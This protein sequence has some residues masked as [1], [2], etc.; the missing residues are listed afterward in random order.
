MCNIDIQEVPKWRPRKKDPATYEQE[1]QKARNILGNTLL[2]SGYTKDQ[3]LHKEAKKDIV[4]LK[5]M[6][7]TC[8]MLLTKVSET[9]CGK[10]FDLKHSAINNAIGRVNDR[11]VDYDY[12]KRFFKVKS[13]VKD[14]IKTA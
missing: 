6:T 8:I 5:H 7:I 14:W 12:S 10:L 13:V 1:L 9:D 4:E 3:F 11:M 2:I